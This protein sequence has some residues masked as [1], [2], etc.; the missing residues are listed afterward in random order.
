MSASLIIWSV[1]FVALVIL[2]L[3]VWLSYRCLNW[4]GLVRYREPEGNQFFDTLG[5]NPFKGRYS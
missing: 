5:A 3:V 2:P 4:R 1:L